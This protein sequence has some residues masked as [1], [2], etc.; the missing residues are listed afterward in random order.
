MFHAYLNNI[1][2][3]WM[4]PTD[5]P[6]QAVP[7]ISFGFFV[8]RTNGWGSTHFSAHRSTERPLYRRR[9][10]IAMARYGETLWLEPSV[11]LIC[12]LKWRNSWIETLWFPKKGVIYMAVAQ[13]PRY[14]DSELVP[15]VFGWLVMIH[16]YILL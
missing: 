9:G 11:I 8:G 1:W 2:M 13:A 12:F 7:W 10:R 4:F 3:S 14:P 6:P 5:E 16:S 15:I